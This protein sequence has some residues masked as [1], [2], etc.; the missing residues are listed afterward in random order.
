MFCWYRKLKAT[1]DEYN[2]RIG[3]QAV[4]LCVTPGKLSQSINAFKVFGSQPLEGVV[5]E[6]P[7]TALDRLVT[8]KQSDLWRVGQF[9]W[10]FHIFN[11]VHGNV[12]LLLYLHYVHR[13]RL[14]SIIWLGCYL[15][16]RCPHEF[17][18]IGATTNFNDFDFID[19]I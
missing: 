1:I 5:R 16:M 12:I 18:S 11:R 19:L 3:Q 10:I 14:G 2:T 17:H 7:N 4:V 13:L 6:C 8:V 15:W 9:L